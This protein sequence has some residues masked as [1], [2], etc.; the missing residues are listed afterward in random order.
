[1]DFKGC[2][3]H[4]SEFDYRDEITSFRDM[5]VEMVRGAASGAEKAGGTG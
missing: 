5:T 1:M 4:F 3:G 2:S